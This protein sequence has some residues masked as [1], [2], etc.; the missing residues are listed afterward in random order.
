M[1]VKLIGGIKYWL[2]WSN[3]AVNGKTIAIPLKLIF[4]SML[5]DGMFADDCKK[6]SAVPI[7]KR[8]SKKFD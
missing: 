3:Y 1:Q 4:W 2:K 6:S 7:H 8:A 5:Q